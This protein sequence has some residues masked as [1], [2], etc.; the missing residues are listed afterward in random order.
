[1]KPL[2][3]LIGVTS[4]FILNE[5]PKSKI[6]RSLVEIASPEIEMTLELRDTVG[7]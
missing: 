1:M 7:V 6:P 2:A 3:F 5:Y 4:C